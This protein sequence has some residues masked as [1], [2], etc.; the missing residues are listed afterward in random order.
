MQLKKYIFIGIIVVI[1]I[2]LV[3]I[4]LSF[5]N[6]NKD[7]P[8]S[9][10]TTSNQNTQNTSKSDTASNQVID[11]MAYGYLSEINPEQII[12][13]TI[14]SDKILKINLSDQTAYS[15]MSDFNSRKP[16]S[17]S[18]LSPSQPII[19]SY[20]VDYGK[21]IMTAQQ[22]NIMPNTIAG[23]VTN[24]NNQQIQIISKEK[25]Y[26]ITI[27]P[28]TIINQFSQNGQTS[29]TINFDQIT[30]GNTVLAIIQG[31]DDNENSI[32]DQIFIIS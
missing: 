21:K 26:S 27:L 28:T 23:T 11:S 15:L 25:V 2:A 1:S 29:G 19:I 13:K 22:I 30:N 24:K 32:A 5:A 16:A 31:Q 7:I 14:N 9:S 4:F 17:F 18:D 8:N 10:K 3:P 20:Q 12:L 6:L